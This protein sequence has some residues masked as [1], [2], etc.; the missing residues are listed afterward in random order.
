MRYQE[1]SK[2]NFRYIPPLLKKNFVDFLLLDNKIFTISSEF[3][4]DIKCV[5]R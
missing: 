3:I 2:K 1:V 4:I 5:F